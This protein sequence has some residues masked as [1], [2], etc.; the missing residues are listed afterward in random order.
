[1]YES[2]FVLSIMLD[3]GDIIVNKI[4]VFIINGEIY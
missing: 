4:I 3:V 1:M 2:M